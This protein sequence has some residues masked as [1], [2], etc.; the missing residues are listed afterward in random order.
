VGEPV[1]APIPLGTSRVLPRYFSRRDF[2]EPPGP[3]IGNLV[4][5][6]R[7]VAGVECILAYCITQ[8]LK[9]AGQRSVA[10]MV[11]VV[12]LLAAATSQAARYAPWKAPPQFIWSLSATASRLLAASC[13]PTTTRMSSNLLMPAEARLLPGGRRRL[14]DDPDTQADATG[15]PPDTPPGTEATG[16]EPTDT[17]PD[18]TP[19]T[20]ATGAE[21]TS[22]DGQPAAGETPGQI[23]DMISAPG[24]QDTTGEGA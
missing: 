20:E 22:T 10:G 7:V 5:V 3:Y 17:P 14:L 4:T 1:A 18:T 6:K 19:D 13:R 9:M 11:V 15:T 2:N 8:R 12:L 23:E 24:D 21:P 16:T